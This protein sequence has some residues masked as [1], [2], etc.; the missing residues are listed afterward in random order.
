FKSSGNVFALAFAPGGRTLA[1]A[2]MGP[3]SFHRGLGVAPREASASIQLWDVATGKERRSL[4]GH[5]RPVRSLA[6]SPDGK[7]L[8]SA[9]DGGLRL[10][11]V[12]T[13][14][15]AHHVTTPAPGG[16][17][18]FTP[19]GKGLVATGGKNVLL[20]LSAQTGKEVRRFEAPANA[21]LRPLA[22]SAD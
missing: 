15:Q 10:W 13:G 6:F 5:K 11:D 12:A 4:H 17:V 9:G 16:G 14:K 2:G 21:S 20:L 1:V 3:E 7:T 22:L 8:A 18:A 19:D